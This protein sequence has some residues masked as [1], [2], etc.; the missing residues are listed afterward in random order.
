MRRIVQYKALDVYI[1]LNIVSE[2]KGRL[3]YDVRTG[4]TLS[5]WIE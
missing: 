5:L 1:F 4:L 2:G 3:D